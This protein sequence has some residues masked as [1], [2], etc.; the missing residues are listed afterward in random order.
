MTALRALAA[1][2]ASDA[3][4]EFGVLLLRPRKVASE[5]DQ[6]FVPPLGTAVQCVQQRPSVALRPHVA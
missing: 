5:V 3:L 6:E 4:D 1:V 2:P